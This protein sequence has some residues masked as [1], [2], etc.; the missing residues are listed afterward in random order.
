VTAIAHK[1]VEMNKRIRQEGGY[2]S[3]DPNRKQNV[4][5]PIAGIAIGNGMT[6]ILEQV[7]WYPEMAYKSGTAPSIINETSYEEM[8]IKIP[9]V[10]QAIRAC[11]QSDE[12]NQCTDAYSEYSDV[13]MTPILETGANVYDLRLKGEYNF[14]AMHAFLNDEK[15]QQKIG[16]RKP[17]VSV[18]VTVYKQL[19]PIDFLH[20]FQ[21]LIP[22]ILDE[23]I[24]VLI[25]A[26]DQDYICNWIGVKAWTDEMDWEGH[27]MYINAPIYDWF[28]GT[29]RFYKN[30]AFA[31]VSGAGHMV[32]MDQ[33]EN[34]LKLF[35]ALLA[36]GD[37]Q[38]SQFND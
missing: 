27:D 36:Q 12:L 16:A 3:S 8:K 29:V 23:G 30:F 5:I 2:D 6:D 20:S 32:P 18:N 31:T 14:S 37:F 19:A 9:K 15:V 38:L 33:P 24:K 28:G 35:R 10:V 22:P 1:I 21:A 7:K 34:S 26:G 4:I 17:W 13:L 11:A 25:Y